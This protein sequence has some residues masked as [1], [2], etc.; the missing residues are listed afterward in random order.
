MTMMVRS[1]LAVLLS[2]AVQAS[3]EPRVCIG[4]DLDHLTATEKNNCRASADR[5]RMDADR[6]HAPADWHF[7][8]I[9]T[10]ADWTMYTS[11]TKHTAGLESLEVDT[12]VQH[13]RTFFRGSALANPDRT[14]V[15]RLIAHEA[16]S[17]LL[18]NGDEVAIQKQVAAW[19]PDGQDP[20][21]VLSAS[22]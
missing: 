17:A 18:G 21:P 22:R 5:L 14:H 9:C 11:L 19:L 10:E 12:D 4:G 13:R 3:A 8:V 15:R 6:F 2:F 1:A 16:A 7:F 20:A